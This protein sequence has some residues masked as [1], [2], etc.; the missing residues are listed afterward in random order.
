VNHARAAAA[1]AWALEI[2]RDAVVAGLEAVANIAG[3][4]EAVDEGQDFDVRI[5]GAK[6][7]GELAQALAA[8][9]AVSGGQVHCVLSAE[10]GQDRT[11]RHALA[12]AAEREADRVVLTLGSPRTEDP[13]QVM[14]E[15]LSG[16]RRPG[17][18]RVEPER[19]AAIEVVL[20]DAR[21]GDAVLI[22]GK[23]RNGYQI[24]A[25]RVETLDDFAV[26]RDWLRARRRTT[27]AR[28]ASR[29]A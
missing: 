15:L 23:G 12:E 3:H 29:S 17:K 4:L 5:D 20:A 8:A 18:V 16:F 19:R 2:D 21:P 28:P 13:H 26:A 6:T 25:D 7:A 9:R 1:L 22:C 14:D 10:G 11:T 24:F 27:H